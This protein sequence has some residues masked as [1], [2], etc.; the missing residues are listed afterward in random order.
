MER[1][2]NFMNRIRTIARKNQFQYMVLENYAIPAVRFTP[3]DYWEKTEIVKKLAKTGKF[4]LEES[5]HDYTC[6]N[7]FCGSVLVFDAHQY[8]DWRAFQARRSRLCDVFFLARR[9]GSDA[10]SKKCQEHYARRAGMMQEFNS[11]YAWDAIASPSR[12]KQKKRQTICR[13][14]EKSVARRWRRE[15]MEGVKLSWKK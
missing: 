8:S 6:Y 15:N 1:T 12:H 2:T 14:A 9:H 7:E 3:N 11:I 4:H 5:K 10:Y 13:R